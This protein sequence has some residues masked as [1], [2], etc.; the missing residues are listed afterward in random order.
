MLT[1]VSEYIHEVI[2]FIQKIMDNG[3]AYVIFFQLNQQ[4]NINAL[5][6]SH[7]VWKHAVL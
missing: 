4:N 5:S 2:A 3:F 7:V 6:Q 1:R